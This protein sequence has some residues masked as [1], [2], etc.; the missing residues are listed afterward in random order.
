MW[1]YLDPL[2]EEL[3]SVL[4]G[5]ARSLSNEIENYYSK[6]YVYSCMSLDTR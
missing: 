6:T 5:W 4:P 1:A 2:S 3:G